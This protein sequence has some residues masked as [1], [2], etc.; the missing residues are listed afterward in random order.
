MTKILNID[1]FCNIAESRKIN[2]SKYKTFGEE[3]DVTNALPDYL[4]NEEFRRRPSNKC[5]MVLSDIYKTI[6][7]IIRVEKQKDVLHKVCRIIAHSAKHKSGVG[8]GVTKQ[9][10]DIWEP[11]Q[12]DFT[13]YF[14][15]IVVSTMMLIMDYVGKELKQHV[16]WENEMKESVKN[17]LEEFS[18]KKPG[19]KFFKSYPKDMIQALKDHSS[20]P[21]Q[22]QSVQASKYT[23]LEIVVSNVAKLMAEYFEPYLKAHQMMSK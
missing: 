7:S 4:F 9:S 19:E 3:N 12:R 20:V 10:H 16:G 2:E 14:P 23:E 22:I 5:N 8:D 11:L 6:S 15:N 18:K 1:E 21:Q 17:T 13:Y